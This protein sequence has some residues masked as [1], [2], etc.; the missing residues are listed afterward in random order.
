MRQFL[1]VEFY[2][3]VILKHSR[4]KCWLRYS[5]VRKQGSKRHLVMAV[6]TVVQWFVLL[7]AVLLYWWKNSLPRV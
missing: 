4:V 5:T 7:K 2:F 6:G 3:K 1:S